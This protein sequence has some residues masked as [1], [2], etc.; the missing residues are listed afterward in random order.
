M[1]LIGTSTEEEGC[2]STIRIETDNRQKRQLRE[3]RAHR[4]EE[5]P[6]PFERCGV[7]I[8]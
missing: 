7:L 3:T 1:V 2:Q 6:Y 5:W 8:S 4:Y